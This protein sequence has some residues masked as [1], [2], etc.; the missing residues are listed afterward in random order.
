MGSLPI[1]WAGLVLIFL[2]VGLLLLEAQQPGIGVFGLTGLI[3][4][5]LG[6]LMLYT[7][8]SPVSPSLPSVSVSPWIIGGVSVVLVIFI[9]FIMRAVLTSKRLPIAT[10][11]A[12]LVG[13]SAIAITDLSPKGIIKLDHE[14]WS[15]VIAPKSKDSFIQSGE[16]VEIVDLDGVILKVKRSPQ[17]NE[18]EYKKQKKVNQL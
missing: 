6:S 3:A 13:K 11:K 10:G 14:N 8:F 4:F 2:G 1:S 12:V 17:S 15:A 9:L 5:V 16:K 18:S 7:P